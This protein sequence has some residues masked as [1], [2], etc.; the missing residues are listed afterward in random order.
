MDL[1]TIK[2]L[3]FTNSTHIYRKNRPTT[4][5][6]KNYDEKLLFFWFIDEHNAVLIKKNY[7]ILNLYAM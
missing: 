2:A 7:F 5:K 4:L 1:R 3:L 6:R